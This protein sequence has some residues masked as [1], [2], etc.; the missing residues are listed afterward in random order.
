MLDRI[1]IDD[2]GPHALALAKEIHRQLGNPFG[3]LPLEEIASDLGIKKIIKRKLKNLE[4][5][6][7]TPPGKAY[8]EILL[9]TSKDPR[10]T[11]FTLAH[12]MG[13]YLH[14]LHH[15]NFNCDTMDLNTQNSANSNEHKQREAEANDFA[16]ELLMPELHMERFYTEIESLTCE[17]L[18]G[19]SDQLFV[20]AEALFRR[21]AENNKRPVA[22]YFIKDN[23]VRY[24][25]KSTCFPKPKIWGKNLIPS[26]SISRI[27][28]GI[29]NSVSA[30]DYGVE[31]QWLR[32]P[33][34]QQLSEQTFKQTNGYQ[35]TLLKVTG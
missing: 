19:L 2:I 31:E 24:F 1:E 28:D 18:V 6:L 25:K 22:A 12:E 34:G 21:I 10:R 13:H 7:F 27:Y 23:K 32:F 30:T 3:K 9:S 29:E 16:A 8:G 4:G 14:P 11:H 35:I 33:N 20:S 17:Q 26:N 5:A 15:G